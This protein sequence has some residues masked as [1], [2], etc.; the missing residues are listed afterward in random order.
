MVHCILCGTANDLAAQYC[1]GLGCG[2]D[3]AAQ[4][5]GDTSLAVQVDCDPAEIE[6]QPGETVAATLTLRNAGSIADKYVLELRRDIGDRITVERHGKPGD[7]LAGEL[8][9][10]TVRYTVPPDW[11][12]AA[13]L[14]GAGGLFGD[15]PDPTAYGAPMDDAIVVPLRVVSTL[16][17]GVA[18]GATLTIRPVSG[19]PE[20]EEFPSPRAARARRNQARRTQMAAAGAV[21]AVAVVVALIVGMASA[22]SGGSD[23][24]DPTRQAVATTTA[25]SSTGAPT[26]EVVPTETFPT[27]LPTSEE[28][29]SATPSRT[30]TTNRTSKPPTTRPPATTP[31][32]PTPSPPTRPPAST[33]PPEPSQTTPAEAPNVVGQN[34]RSA[35][36][37]LRNAGFG[38]ARSSASDQ[39]CLDGQG[40]F[41]CTVSAQSPV[42]TDN[43][44]TL[45]L[46]APRASETPT[47]SAPG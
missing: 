14:V 6:A 34:Y 47:E 41:E 18:A 13:H 12:P 9:V 39:Q 28:P 15:G 35:R 7:V 30:P 44:V 27:E 31:A 3:L 38:V 5:D 20:P 4:R 21:A 42:D 8:C 23:D 1:M 19:A 11:S 22:G 16:D 29:T 24:K 43:T 17:R 37:T 32:R 46:Q 10:W 45:T 33:P 40:S 26:D 2:A 36:S 25:P